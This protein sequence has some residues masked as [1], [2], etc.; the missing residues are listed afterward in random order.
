MPQWLLADVTRLVPVIPLPPRLP[1]EGFGC[2]LVFF[3]RLNPADTTIPWLFPLPL[4]KYRRNV[5]LFQPCDIC[6]AQGVPW[7][8]TTAPRSPPGAQIPAV[9][10]VHET[11]HAV[12]VLSPSPLLFHPFF[13]VF[14]P[15]W[16]PLGSRA[17]RSLPHLPS[18]SLFES[19]DARHASPVCQLSPSSNY[20]LR[21]RRRSSSLS[22]HQTD[23]REIASL[24]P[25]PS[26]PTH[27]HRAGAQHRA[28][29]P[30][31]PKN[32]P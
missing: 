19:H 3:Q 15:P 32:C 17:A 5:F 24:T 11:A 10:G 14:L 2:V 21:L 1:L 16:S 7:D 20:A 4:S 31:T 30:T 27:P 12:F 18:P 23:T 28:H 22:R 8:V 29:S 6:H 13:G 25:S 26:C 9:P